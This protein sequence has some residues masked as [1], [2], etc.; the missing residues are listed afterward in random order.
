MFT[1]FQIG[2]FITCGVLALS[3]LVGLTRK[4]EIQIRA[5]TWV[6]RIALIVMA[7]GGIA[8][9]ITILI[10]KPSLVV[11]LSALIKGVLGFMTI[12][13]MEKTFSYKKDGTLNR[14]KVICVLSSYALTVICGFVLL[15]ITGGFGAL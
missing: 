5:W 14:G 10:S 8:L 9:E 11:I 4:D 1:V 7:I 15:W 3:L 13:L 12:Y 2:H 6:N